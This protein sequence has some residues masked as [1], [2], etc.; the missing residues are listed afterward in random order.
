MIHKNPLVQD[1]NIPFEPE[2]VFGPLL[3]YTHP[4]SHFE[5]IEINGKA[6]KYDKYGNCTGWVSC[7]LSYDSNLDWE[8]IGIWDPI[9]RQIQDYHFGYSYFN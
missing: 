3:F 4:S 5:N 7:L 8:E 6:Y 2:V 9:N 1:S